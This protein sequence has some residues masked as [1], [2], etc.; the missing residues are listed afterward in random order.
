VPEVHITADKRTEFGKG[1]ARRIRRTGRVPAVI[2]GHGTDPAH[3]SLPGH[4]LMQALKTANVLLQVKLGADGFLTLPKAVQR[5]PVRQSLE[6]VDLVIVRSGEKVTVEVPVTVTGRVP[7][8][9]MELVIGGPMVNAEATHIPAEFVVDVEGAEIGTTVRAGDI[10]LPSGTELAGDPDQI[11]V[12]IAAPLAE[13]EVVPEAVEGEAAEVP[14][15]DAE[16]AEATTG[17]N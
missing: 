16:A 15:G 2:Y 14:E 1:A 7:G 8:G 12:T 5:N 9:V 11:V 3:V 13:E 10:D 6:H 4:E 17:D